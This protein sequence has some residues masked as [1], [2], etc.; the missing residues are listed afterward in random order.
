M[1]RSTRRTAPTA[2]R[3]KDGSIA[4]SARSRLEGPLTD[5]QKRRLMEIA[6]RCPVHQT[7]TSEVDIRTRLA[8]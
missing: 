5:E 6:D 8:A 1:P 3:R 4:S 7:L 2:K